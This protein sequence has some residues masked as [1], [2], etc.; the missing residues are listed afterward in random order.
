MILTL[1]NISKTYDTKKALD[2]ISF[3]LSEGKCLCI[4]GES[5]AG[6]STL[7]RIIAGLISADEGEIQRSFEKNEIGMIFQDAALMTPI[8]VRDNIAYGLHHTY[9]KDELND[10]V[11]EVA[12]QVKI[13][14]LLNRYPA[15]LSQGEKQRVSIARAL[16]RKPKIL[17]MD[18]PTANLDY[19]LKEVID[20]LIFS[21]KQSGMSMVLATHD[22]KEAKFLSDEIVFLNAGKVVDEGDY[23]RLYKAPSTVFTA[24]FLGESG[25]VI[26]EGTIQNQCL[27]TMNG[28]LP[29]KKSYTDQP[30]LVG[31]RRDAVV[32]GNAF[33]L[34]VVQR[35]ATAVRLAYKDTYFD[36]NLSE[37]QSQASFT[38]DESQMVFFDPN[39][40]VRIS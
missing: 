4:L 1:Q 32:T 8:P 15:S 22:Q 20:Q 18:E 38:L 11:K 40:K 30:V 39:T 34:P 13:E 37:N 28:C 7:L 17:L 19:R 3:S 5:G 9:S 26:I 12:K 10:M 16:I 31:F 33:C 21:I 14:P 36:V 29:L 2:N 25:M 24:T 6:K 23:E 27:Y 35:N